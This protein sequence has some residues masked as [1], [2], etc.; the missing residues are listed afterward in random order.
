MAVRICAAVSVVF[1]LVEFIIL[2]GG[3]HPG[4]R[5]F[6]PQVLEAGGLFFGFLALFIALFTGWP[7]PYR[8][9]P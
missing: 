6:H 2:L 1:F 3:L 9:V 5:L 4:I 7:S 8:R